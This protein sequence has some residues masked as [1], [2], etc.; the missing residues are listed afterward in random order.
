VDSGDLDPCGE[1]TPELFVE[2][3]P[4]TFL[5]RE[6]V[7]HADFVDDQRYVRVRG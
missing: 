2:L 1:N 6:T 3:I 4:A 5:P 7:H